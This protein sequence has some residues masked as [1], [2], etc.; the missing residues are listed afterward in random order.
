MMDWWKNG[1]L[2]T[3]NGLSSSGSSGSDLNLSMTDIMNL[4]LGDML[5]WNE[6]GSGKV[7][8]GEKLYQNW[9]DAHST[10][11]EGVGSK[12]LRSLSRLICAHEQCL[13]F[14]SLFLI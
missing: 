8:W 6:L 4:G 7:N 9:G 10:F 2:N 1:G 5:N 13:G 14:P 11:Y 3:S 12:L